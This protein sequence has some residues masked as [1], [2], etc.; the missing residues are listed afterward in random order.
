MAE[1]YLNITPGR[2][3]AQIWKAEETRQ[4]IKDGKLSYSKNLPL[5]VSYIPDQRKYL[6]LDGH[7]RAIELITDGAKELCCL[8]SEHQPKT[9]SIHN[10]TITLKKLL[11]P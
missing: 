11:T 1:K 3:V 2:L 9:Y 6:I 7:H 10:Q 8:I 5:L 4:D